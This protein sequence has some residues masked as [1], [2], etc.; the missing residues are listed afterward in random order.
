MP[1]RHTV[2][3]CHF[4]AFIHIY[5]LHVQGL[6]C[7]FKGKMMKIHCICHYQWPEQS[8]KAMFIATCGYTAAWQTMYSNRM[9]HEKILPYD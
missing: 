3:L 6:D 1:I 8:T 4:S 5:Q 7:P 9:E 2:S